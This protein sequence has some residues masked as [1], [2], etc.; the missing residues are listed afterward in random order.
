[1]GATNKVAAKVEEEKEQKPKASGGPPVFSR[2]G[3]APAKKA[4]E[5]PAADAGGFGGFRSN[6]TSK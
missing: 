6:Q 3:K 1:M 5:K 2:S 4:E